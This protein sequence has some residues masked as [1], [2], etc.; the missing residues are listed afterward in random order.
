MITGLHR[1]NIHTEES[2]KYIKEKRGYVCL[3]REEAKKGREKSCKRVVWDE[4]EKKIV[5]GN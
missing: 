5:A 1:Y 3:Q 4:G 2:R